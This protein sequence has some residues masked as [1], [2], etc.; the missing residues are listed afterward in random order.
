MKHQKIDELGALAEIVPFE[1]AQNE[2]PR[3]ARAL[4]QRAR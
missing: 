1:T 2:P 3:T 4:G